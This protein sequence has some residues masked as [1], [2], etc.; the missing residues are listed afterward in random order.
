MLTFV[1]AKAHAGL[2]LVAGTTFHLRRTRS[3][4]GRGSL[5][6]VI[7]QSLRKS[8]LKVFGLMNS[9]VDNIEQ[10]RQRLRASAD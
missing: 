8:L 9:V 3:I 5:T 6:V 2:G 7:S 1:G 4:L 10:I